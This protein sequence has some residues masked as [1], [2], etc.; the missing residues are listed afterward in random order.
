MA[1]APRITIEDVQARIFNGEDF[2]FIDTRNPNAWAE[3][4]VKI[5]GAIRVPLDALDDA[6]PDIPK[7][8]PIVTY[9]T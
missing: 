2:A 9:C 8:K 7:D 3:S 6:L 5:P 1:D 4:D